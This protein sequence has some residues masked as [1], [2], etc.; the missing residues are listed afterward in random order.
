[1]S[2]LYEGDNIPPTLASFYRQCQTSASGSPRESVG[3]HLEGCGKAA[4]VVAAADA[5][6]VGRMI[7]HTVR[8]CSLQPIDQISRDGDC[9]GNHHLPGVP[10]GQVSRAESNHSVGRACW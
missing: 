10:I 9:G 7:E 4:A 5:E 1:V 3:C 8:T 6:E 2:S